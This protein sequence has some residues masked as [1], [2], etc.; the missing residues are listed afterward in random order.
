MASLTPPRPAP[1]TRPK[2]T[3]KLLEAYWQEVMKLHAA[4][5]NH[6]LKDGA[7]AMFGVIKPALETTNYFTYWESKIEPFLLAAA[8]PE[9]DAPPHAPYLKARACWVYSQYAD[10]IDF[11]NDKMLGVAAAKI[12]AVS[13]SRRV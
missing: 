6:R 5:P 1:Q 7:L 12:V 11:Q 8:L 13:D 3:M 4:T 10:S 9:F 2:A